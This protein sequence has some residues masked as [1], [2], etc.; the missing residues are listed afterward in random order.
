LIPRQAHSRHL[1]EF[2]TETFKGVFVLHRS[3]ES[4]F[5]LPAARFKNHL[6]KFL[7]KSP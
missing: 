1:D 4:I 6:R 5:T 7:D 3:L 2:S